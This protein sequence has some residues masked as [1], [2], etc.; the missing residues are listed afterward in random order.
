FGAGIDADADGTTDCRVELPNGVE[1]FGNGTQ[2][3]GPSVVPLWMA[4][5]H[6]GLEE[7]PGIT[8][9]ALSFGSQTGEPHLSMSARLQRFS[10]IGDDTTINGDY[11]P[12]PTADL[13]LM[14]G[15]LTFVDPAPASATYVRIELVQPDQSAVIFAPANLDVITLPDVAPLR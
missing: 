11:L 8:V 12:L 1:P 6:S 15:V 10:E 13:D 9:A 2:P 5:P 7:Q 14:S 4:P 3:L